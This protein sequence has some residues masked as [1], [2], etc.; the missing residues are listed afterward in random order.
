MEYQLGEHG[1]NLYRELVELHEGL[2]EE[3]SEALNARLIIA[4]MN[5]LGNAD[6][7]REAFLSAS[8]GQD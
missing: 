1:D 3:E 6:K 4:L 2:S 8:A 5:A 7:I